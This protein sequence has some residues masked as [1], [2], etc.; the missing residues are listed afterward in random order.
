MAQRRLLPV[1][2]VA[3]GGSLGVHRCRSIVQFGHPRG[4][5]AR[6]HYACCILEKAAKASRHSPNANYAMGPMMRAP[7]A[8]GRTTSII[9]EERRLAFAAVISLGGGGVDTQIRVERC[10]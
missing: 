9:A 4:G 1:Q 6:N 5:G 10:P 3:A 7:D 8:C 2:L